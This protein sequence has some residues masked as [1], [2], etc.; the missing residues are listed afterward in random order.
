MIPCKIDDVKGWVITKYI[1]LPFE[2]SGEKVK[3]MY[4]ANVFDKAIEERRIDMKTGI[5]VITAKIKKKEMESFELLMSHQEKNMN[6][7]LE[8]F[9]KVSVI[10]DLHKVYSKKSIVSHEE[11]LSVIEQL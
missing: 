8:I 2:T 7:I 6:L 1:L 10:N 4:L 9:P 5:P 3:I 11:M